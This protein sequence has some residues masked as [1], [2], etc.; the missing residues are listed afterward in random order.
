MRAGPDMTNGERNAVA[1]AMAS[2]LLAVGA[3]G[4]YFYGK[5]NAAN[6]AIKPAVSRD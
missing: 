5:G 2:V 1:A 3:V 4:G 6:T